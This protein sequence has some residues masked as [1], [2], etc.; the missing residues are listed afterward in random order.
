MSFHTKIDI[1]EFIHRTLLK[2]QPKWLRITAL[3]TSS[4][5]FA[6]ILNIAISEIVE[7]PKMSKINQENHTIARQFDLLRSQI[8]TTSQQVNDIKH[9]DHFVYRPLLGVD[10]LDIAQV[11]ADYNDNKYSHITDKEYGSLMKDTW[12]D[13][14]RLARQ[15]Y[16]TSLSLDQ[17]QDL[18][19]NKEE[20]SMVIPAIWPIDRTKLRSIS[21]LYGMRNHPRYK[22]W[23]MH[24][25]VDL[26]APIGTAVYATGN[27]IVTMAGWQPGY[28]QLIEINHGFG[29]KSRYGHL[30]KRHVVVGDS[31]TRGQVIGDV[32]NSG[33]SSGPHLH[34]EVRFR[35]NTVNPINY[36]DKNMSPEAYQSLME[37]IDASLQK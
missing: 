35:N 3:I 30:S 6:V 5:V 25:G 15:L 1:K 33:V 19:E 29:Y 32:G 26:A 4:F 13:L 21:S 20:F 27:G 10:T 22:T 12:R 8:A 14:D 16:Y 11:Y 7:T 37:Q 2:K 31:V 23:M 17:T 34:Y 28:G 24:R 18:A 9:R 36:F